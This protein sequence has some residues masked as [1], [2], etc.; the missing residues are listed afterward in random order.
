[1]IINQLSDRMRIEVQDN[2]K[3]CVKIINEP[4]GGRTSY[5]NGTETLSFSSEQEVQQLIDSIEEAKRHLWG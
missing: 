1:M 5:A 2:T 3:K 4:Y